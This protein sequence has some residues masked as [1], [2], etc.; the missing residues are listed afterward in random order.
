[1]NVI[2]YQQQPPDW[3]QDECLRVGIV[4]VEQSLELEKPYLSFTEG[5]LQ[6]V[7]PLEKK[8]KPIF[9]DFLEGTVARRLQRVDSSGE[10]LKKVF[11]KNLKNKNYFDA[12]PGLG[13]DSMI[14]LKL[15]LN[16]YACEKNPIVYLLLL[17]GLKRYFLENRSEEER[18]KLEFGDSLINFRSFKDGLFDIVYVDLMFEAST[19]KSKSKKGMETLKMLMGGEGSPSEANNSEWIEEFLLEP[20]KKLVYKLS[21]IHI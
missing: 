17:D 10:V 20:W 15:G 21:L 14:A 13:V 3:L 1:M 8:Q 12:T 11:G 16:V 18:Y 5:K 19:K 7:N 2:S 6:L 4:C 9:V